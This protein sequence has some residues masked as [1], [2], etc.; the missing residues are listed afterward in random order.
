MV[1]ICEDAQIKADLVEILGKMNIPLVKE[2]DTEKCIEFIKNDKKA[3]GDTIDVIKVDRI[4]EA[5][6]QKI[7]I[8]E[9]RKYFGS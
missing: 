7:K 9:L 1:M 6:I 8:D 5:Y 4:G 3:S 2:P